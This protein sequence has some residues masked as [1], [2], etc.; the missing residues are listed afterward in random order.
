MICAFCGGETTFGVIRTVGE[1]GGIP[2]VELEI[3]KDYTGPR[4]AACYP[5]K[6]CYKEA[7]A[8]WATLF[9]EGKLP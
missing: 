8:Y 6:D 2:E 1:G 9:C 7:T 3:L 5:I 4:R